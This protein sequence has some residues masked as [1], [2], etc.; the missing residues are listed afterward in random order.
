MLL[1]EYDESL[2]QEIRGIWRRLFLAYKLS[3]NGNLAK[4]FLESGPCVEDRVKHYHFVGKRFF[5]AN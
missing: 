1:A 2:Q 3:L 4:N 5:P